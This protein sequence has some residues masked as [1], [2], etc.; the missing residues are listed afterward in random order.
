M[1]LVC[2]GNKY[3]ADTEPW[4]VYKTNPQ[5]VATILNISM[6]ITANLGVLLEPFLPFTAEKIR[7]M[8]N[9]NGKD[10]NL[11]GGDNLLLPGHQLNE[12]SLLFDKIEDDVIERQLEKL[13]KAKEANERANI[14]VTP[15]KDSV[16]YDEFS[17]MDIRIAK[18]LE[19]ERVPKTQK[20][21]KLKIDTGVDTRT[22]VSGI[23]EFFTPE[24]MVGKQVVV[25]ANLE[26]RTIRGIESHGM[27]LMAEDVDGRL[28]LV[29]PADSVSNGSTV[30]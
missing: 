11:A 23:A 3:L 10:W 9:L 2:L 20:L 22:I 30:K 28:Q 16:T 8:V 27:I 12:P 14:K 29:I 13:R 15:L 4:K 6:Q 19:A 18:V 7:A 25:L 21:L 24:Q 26:P 5:R 1:N 17:K